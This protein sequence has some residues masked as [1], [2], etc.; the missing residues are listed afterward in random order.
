MQDSRSDTDNASVVSLSTC[1]EDTVEEDQIQERRRN[2]GHCGEFHVI[3]GG[4]L[5]RKVMWDTFSTY[6]EIIQ[7]YIN[8]VQSRYKKCVIVFDGYRD[9]PST[10]YHEHRRRLMKVVISPD[11]CANLE[12]EFSSTS[13][14]AFL[15][16]S[17]S[18]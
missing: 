11:V 6:N 8:Y 15:S 13:Q 7:K 10:K 16:N 3:N 2:T 5:F 4:Y 1:E 14:I 18:I 17:L 9:G 12:S